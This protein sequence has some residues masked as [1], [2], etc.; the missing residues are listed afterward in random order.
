MFGP[1][2]F[3]YIANFKKFKNLPKS[4]N[5]FE[6][7]GFIGKGGYGRVYKVIDKVDERI[8]AVKKIA[9]KGILINNF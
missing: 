1:G 8:Y 2:I 7:L 6:D 3:R 4:P 5:H 9:F